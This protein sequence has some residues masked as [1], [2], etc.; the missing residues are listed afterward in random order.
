MVEAVNTLDDDEDPPP[1]PRKRKKGVPV[2]SDS[3]DSS[4]NDEEQPVRPRKKKRGTVPS[5]SEQLMAPLLEAC[6]VGTHMH[7]RQPWLLL[8]LS[9]HIHARSVASL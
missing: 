2:L 5:L 6:Q 9:A 3:S 8:S 7:L 1:R 4:D